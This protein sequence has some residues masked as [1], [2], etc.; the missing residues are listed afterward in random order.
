M[1]SAGPRTAAAGERGGGGAQEKGQARTKAET[2]RVGSAELMEL[3]SG[4]Y[5]PANEAPSAGGTR[6]RCDSDD[7]R[8]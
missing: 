6:K 8:R 4:S 3:L 1:G 5:F 2:K 7:S